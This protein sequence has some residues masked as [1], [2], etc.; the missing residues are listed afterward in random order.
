MAGDDTIPPWVKVLIEAQ[1][2]NRIRQEEAQEANRIRQEE[3]MRAIL[4]TLTTNQQTASS[5][6][7]NEHRG[8]DNIKI[9]A[10]AR[11]PLLDT[12][13]TYSKFRSW[14]TIW[15]D[16]QMLTKLDQLPLNIQKAEFRSCLTEEMRI[17]IKCAIDI[18][19]EDGS[20]IEEILDKIQLHLRQKRNVALDRVYFEQRTQEENESFDDFYVAIKQL[21]EEADLCDECKNQRLTT[22]IMAS[23]N[24]QELRQK[25]L[26]LTPFPTLQTVVNLCRSQ[27][28]AIKDASMLGGKIT[29]ERVKKTNYQKLKTE[30][31]TNQNINQ[32]STKEHCYRCGYEKHKFLKCPAKESTCTICSKSGHWAKMCR[33]KVSENTGQMNSGIKGNIKTI[34]ISDIKGTIFSKTPRV[35]INCYVDKKQ[36]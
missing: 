26:A 32:S 29:I 20:T 4:A 15:N 23:V 35:D 25:L 30:N 28:T 17:H 13:T 6:A 24:D 7:A 19:D 5:T 11:P 18:H 27:E 16:Y 31:F 34:R 10:P 12:T 2:A 36:Q 21:A 33:T 22:K 14:R 8:P 9:H 1:E 3:T